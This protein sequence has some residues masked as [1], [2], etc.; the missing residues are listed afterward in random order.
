MGSQ[1]YRAQMIKLKEFAKAKKLPYSVRERLMAHYRHL[2]PDQLIVNEEEIVRDLPPRMRHELVD[3]LHGSKASNFT[4][5]TIQTKA[6]LNV[7]VGL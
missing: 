6:D 2:Y 3:S 7:G 1:E 4:P 5:C